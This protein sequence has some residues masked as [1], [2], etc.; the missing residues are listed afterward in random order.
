MWVV[1]LGLAI[2]YNPS[3]HDIFLVILSYLLMLQK[4][5]HW[6]HPTFRW[7]LVSYRWANILPTLVRVLG[8]LWS[9]RIP[10]RTPCL[11][12]WLVF[13]LWL[14]TRDLKLTAPT[15]VSVS[16]CGCLHVLCGILIVFVQ[17]WAICYV[18]Y[19]MMVG[20]HGPV[21]YPHLVVY[22]CFT[23]IPLMG[24]EVLVLYSPSM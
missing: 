14:G 5:M 21:W 10:W 13:T 16:V 22:I 23:H 4:K 9:V 8:V 2:N 1:L 24:L 19:C 6:C 3:I 15:L 17:F 11:P 7:C 18:S 20:Y 12:H